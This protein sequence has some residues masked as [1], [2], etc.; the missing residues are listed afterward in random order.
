MK[1][2]NFFKLFSIFANAFLYLLFSIHGI[3]AVHEIFC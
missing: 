3:I 2:R 1:G